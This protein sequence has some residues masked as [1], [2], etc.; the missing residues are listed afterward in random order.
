MLYEV[1]T[2]AIRE[3]CKHVKTPAIAFTAN[4]FKEQ[5]QEYYAAGFT[6][7]ICKPV[8][9]QSLKSVIYRT[10]SYAENMRDK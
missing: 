2:R 10:L 9:R 5:I 4:S 1:I 6:S 3:D 7:Y 8:K